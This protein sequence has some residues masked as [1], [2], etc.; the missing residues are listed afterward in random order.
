[1]GLCKIEDSRGKTKLDIPNT[2]LRHSRIAIILS[3]FRS[4]S[5]SWAGLETTVIFGKT[6]FD[7]TRGPSSHLHRPIPC[8]SQALCF[9]S[10]QLTLYFS[11]SFSLWFLHASSS[12][13]C[14][15]PYPML[16]SGLRSSLPR[17][18]WMLNFHDSGI[19]LRFSGSKTDSYCWVCLAKHPLSFLLPL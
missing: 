6:P 7:F 15:E 19:T 16:P 14:F 13:P 10:S 1:M 4:N 18:L 17:G 11:C 3:T 12:S 2:E 9:S 8:C 5:S